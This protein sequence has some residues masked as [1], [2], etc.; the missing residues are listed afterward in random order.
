MDRPIVLVVDD[1][2]DLRRTVSYLLG[3]VCRVI[4]A[5]NGA[6]AL[7]SVRREHPS[8]MLLDMEMPQMDGT[9]VLK[10]ARQLD[11]KL[12]VIMLTGEQEIELAERTLKLGA[13]EYVTKPFDVDYL[14]GEVRRLLG[15]E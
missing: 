10:A 13:T 6:E 2:G 1:D 12:R 8:L 14:K 3:P 7:E 4:E 15:L 9:A 11:P 5:S